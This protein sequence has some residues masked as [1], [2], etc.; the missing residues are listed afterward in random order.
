MTLT[1]MA[2]DLFRQLAWAKQNDVNQKTLKRVYL[3]GVGETQCELHNGVTCDLSAVDR[4]LVYKDAINYVKEHWK[5]T[6]NSDHD[7]LVF[8][9]KVIVDNLNVRNVRVMI[10]TRIR[11]VRK[12]MRLTRADLSDITGFPEE[13]IEALEKG[14]YVPR[15]EELIRIYKALDVSIIG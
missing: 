11:N 10:G 5:D 2:Y 9:R 1:I 3:S 14:K 15:I 12:H 6:E 8:Y 13:H 7:L 4:N